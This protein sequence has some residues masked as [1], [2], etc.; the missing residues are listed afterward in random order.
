MLTVNI[1]HQGD[2]RTIEA[3]EVTGRSNNSSFEFD[4][5]QITGADGEIFS[6][7]EGQVF[8]MNEAGATVARYNFR[9][10]VQSKCKSDSDQFPKSPVAP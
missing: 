8:V 5:A 1:C 7:R 2:Q 10:R 6:V 3:R 9:Q 4:E